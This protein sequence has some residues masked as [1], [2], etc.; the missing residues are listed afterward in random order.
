VNF[1]QFRAAIHILTVNCAEIIQD[2]PGQP[3]YEM[4]GIKHRF[5]GCK[6]WP[7]RF[8]ESSVRGHQIWV[9]PSKRAVCATAVQS[10]KRTVGDRHR[11]AAYH[12]KHCCLEPQTYGFLVIFFH[13]LWLPWGIA[14]SVAVAVGVVWDG[15]PA[16]QQLVAV[17]GAAAVAAADVRDWSALL[18]D[19]TSCCWC[20]TQSS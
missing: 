4:F 20:S 13:D 1:S 2:I 8:N 9:P 17:H 10:S 16:S 15:V 5:L 19:E 12:N 11:L 6:A 18:W 7:P 3:A 14:M